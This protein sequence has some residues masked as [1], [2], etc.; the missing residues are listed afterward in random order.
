MTISTSS[1]PRDRV[2][3][4]VAGLDD[5][6]GGGLPAR[7]L[8]LAQGSPGSGKTT[9]AL[10][11][12]LEG[13]R[14]GEPCLY[15][16]LSETAEEVKAVADSHGWSLDGV[17]IFEALVQ[18]SAV[19]E[20]NTL[21]QPAEI[22]LGERMKFILAEVD[23][24]QPTRVVLDSCSELR[25]LAQSP[26]RY[27]QQILALKHELVTRDRTVLLIDNPPP[28][29]P[30]VLVQSIAHGVIVMEQLTPLFGAERRRL[31]VMKLRG[32]SYRGGLHDFVIR[33]GGLQVFPRLVA[34]E[35]HAEPSQKL[36]SSGMKELDD[37]LGGGPAR[38]S[39]TLLMGPAGCGKSAI[40]LQ[41][42]VAAAQ[43]GERCAIFAFDETFHTTLTRARSLGTPLEPYLESGL[44]MLQQVDPAELSPG[45]FDH[46]VRQAVETRGARMVV[47]DS[48]S[49]YLK[50][51]PDAH[52]L[53]VQLHE[54]L[55]YL[56]QQDVL[57]FLIVAQ[58][59][60]VGPELQSP[61]DVSYLADA[62]VLLRYFET[63][64]TVRKA[65]S[66]MKKRSGAHESSIRE[67]TLGPEGLKVGPPLR[68]FRGVLTGVPK[69]GNAA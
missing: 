7:R 16:S 13:A 39:S 2:K 50:A 12:L 4:G 23:R 40:S 64:G 56:G 44:I 47:I 67:L 69:Y 53:T 51:M 60:V 48:L 41:Y 54:L 49:G 35:H 42:A 15:I 61:S 34:A 9:L 29:A 3:T 57:T 31:R 59:G 17:T 33:K 14:Q 24:L 32:T 68:E 19:E 38:G 25:L 27:R 65:L 63:Q 52:F 45:E 37:L 20:E 46:T 10:Q 28:D 26:L 1:P 62:V 11:F 43:R 36:V 5:I 22:E 55:T 8:Y 6:L 66:V 21:F 58:H 30:D 18:D